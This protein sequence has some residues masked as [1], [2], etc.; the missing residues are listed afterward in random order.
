MNKIEHI[1][2]QKTKRGQGSGINHFYQTKL[3]HKDLAKGDISDRTEIALSDG[4]SWIYVKK[5]KD[6]VKVK[7]EWENRI[8]NTLIPIHYVGGRL[9]NNSPE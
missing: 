2:E 6:L 9:S 5:G 8:I 7:A 1:R 4:R 3:T